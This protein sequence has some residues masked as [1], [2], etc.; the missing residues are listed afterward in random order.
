MTTEPS[1]LH[2]WTQI[3]HHQISVEKELWSIWKI[4]EAQE[5]KEL[6]GIF[7]TCKV[8][9]NMYIFNITKKG[10]GNALVANI[11]HIKKYMRVEK[12][13]IWK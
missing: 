9:S 4:L 1:R 7:F 11:T 6:S 5:H 10:W 12:S 2:G 3:E 13:D 8:I